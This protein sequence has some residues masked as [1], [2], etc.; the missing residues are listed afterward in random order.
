MKSF[1]FSLILLIPSSLLAQDSPLM[2]NEPERHY[3][4][5]DRLLP[6]DERLRQR[7]LGWQELNGVSQGEAIEQSGHPGKDEEFRKNRIRK[8][9]PPS[10]PRDDMVEHTPRHVPSS[11]PPH[12]VTDMPASTDSV[13]EA[14][15]ARYNGPGNSSDL[16]HALAVDGNGN[17]YVTGGTYGSGSSY[18]YAT[19]KYDASG[20]EQWVARYNG[21]G[22]WSD[23][24]YALAVDGSGNV[25]VTGTV[26]FRYSESSSYATIKYDASGVEQWVALYSGPVNIDGAYALAVDS[27]GNVHVTGWSAGSGFRY[28]YATI[29]YDASGAQQWVA[30]YDAPRNSDDYAYALAVDGSGNVYVA[31]GSIGSG[32]SN[33]YATIKYD[34]SG[35]EQWVAR[36]NGSGNADDYA[37]ALA[38]DA[39]GNVYVTGSTCNVPQ[40]SRG[41]L[42]GFCRDFFKLR[43][44]AVQTSW[45]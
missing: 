14:W 37:S 44:G 41:F 36:Y 40:K 20:V 25:Y 19:I 45:D 4:G 35:S 31:G 10:R 17:V 39:E 21:P 9:L 24:A 5:E 26:G 18:D 28:D 23:V 1:L 3:E 16:A 6:P 13:A 27:S 34:A 12:S 22:D 15:V 30:R 29:K 42:L 33:D 32:T 43:Q 7:M 2:R 11:S 8:H 38:V